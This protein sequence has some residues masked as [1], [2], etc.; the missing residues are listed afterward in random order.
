MLMGYG[1]WMVQSSQ[2][3]QGRTSFGLWAGFLYCVLCTWCRIV[4][5]RFTRQC[6][7]TV[8]QTASTSTKLQTKSTKSSQHEVK[9][10][11]SWRVYAIINATEPNEE[12]PSFCA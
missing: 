10:Q 9:T 11:S 8:V 4:N 1:L 3:Y 7:E 2:T 5:S 6:S 12:S